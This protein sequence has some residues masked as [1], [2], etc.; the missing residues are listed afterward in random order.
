M[1]HKGETHNLKAGHPLNQL[2]DAE[3]IQLL[4]TIDLSYK[5]LN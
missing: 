3:I 2:S 5:N 4:L 1:K